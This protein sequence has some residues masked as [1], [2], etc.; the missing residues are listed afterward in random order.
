MQNL[1]KINHSY[2]L[3]FPLP[4]LRLIQIT[5]PNLHSGYYLIV[6]QGTIV[7]VYCDTSLTCGGITGGWTGVANLDNTT[8]TS[9]NNIELTRPPFNSCRQLRKDSGYTSLY[10]PV[11]SK[12]Y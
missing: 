6:N 7:W 10:Y 1:F 8:G 2:N 12:Q 9:P 4:V 3:Y 11:F 5:T